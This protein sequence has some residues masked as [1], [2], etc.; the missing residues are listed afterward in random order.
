MYSL[1][2]SSV[3][4]ERQNCKFL[5]TI[6]SS[7]RFTLKE[8]FGFIN[9]RTSGFV[10]VYTDVFPLADHAIVAIHVVREFILVLSR[11]VEVF[12]RTI[13]VVSNKLGSVKKTTRMALDKKN[14]C[15]RA[16][17]TF[18]YFFVAHYK[19]TARND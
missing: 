13:V 18:V 16:L 5:P 9:F 17:K 3:Q 12:D 14:S 11:T 6:L 8:V 4:T 1:L 19:T 10:G 2:A 15:E 7:C